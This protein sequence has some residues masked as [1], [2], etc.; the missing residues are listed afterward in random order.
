M[1]GGGRL[2]TRGPGFVVGAAPLSVPPHSQWGNGDRA[3]VK[4]EQHV[5]FSADG[6]RTSAPT[7][8]LLLSITIQGVTP[9]FSKTQT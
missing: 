3:L 6:F 1:A 8:H 9:S 5:R 4:M 7:R 2:G